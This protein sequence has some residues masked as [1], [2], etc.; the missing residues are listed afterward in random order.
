MTL[1][2]HIK[3]LNNLSKGIKA[4]SL[5]RSNNAEEIIECYYSPVQKAILIHSIG[6]TDNH[7]IP[8]AVIKYSRGIYILELSKRNNPYKT[9]AYKSLKDLNKVLNEVY[10]Y[11]D[12][13]FDIVQ[14]YKQEFDKL[15]KSSKADKTTSA[16]LLRELKLS[17][18][19]HPYATDIVVGR[20]DYNNLRD[21]SKH[22]Q[23]FVVKYVDALFS[24]IDVEMGKIYEIA[25]DRLEKS[26]KKSDYSDKAEVVRH[27]YKLILVLEKSLTNE[28]VTITGL[29]FDHDDE[30]EVYVGDIDN[31]GR[32]VKTLLATNKELNDV[33]RNAL[34][35]FSKK[36]KPAKATI[37]RQDKERELRKKA[38]Q[39]LSSAVSPLR[40]QALKKWGIHNY[41]T[42]KN[43]I[44]FD[45]N[46]DTGEVTYSA[47]YKFYSNQ[48]DYSTDTIEYKVKL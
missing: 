20:A 22:Q 28:T 24:Y 33:L 34:V 7:Y 30:V 36:Y 8:S 37:N 1:T 6:V 48:D 23:P 18:K 38:E 35:Q 3:A 29:K 5:T 46:V 26:L 21:F 9:K 10:R 45:I 19:S 17:F 40:K 4:V 2:K 31:D 44:D 32:V 13:S 27:I 12:I 41:P 11:N 43:D 14:E 15:V 42:N 25:L 39:F 16:R 47:S